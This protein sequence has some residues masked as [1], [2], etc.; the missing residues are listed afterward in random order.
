MFQI[1]LAGQHLHKDTWYC[2]H[3]MSFYFYEGA[4]ME[5][6][7]GHVN[8]NI[9]FIDCMILILFYKVV[10]LLFLSIGHCHFGI[11]KVIILSTLLGFDLFP[12]VYGLSCRMKEE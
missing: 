4:H 8:P 1:Q 9:Q 10:I 2:S 6:L 11:C 5:D 7:C 12:S 3:S